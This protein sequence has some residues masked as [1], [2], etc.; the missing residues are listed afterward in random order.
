MELGQA[1]GVEQATYELIAALA[2]LDRKNT[3]RVL[4][5]RAACWEWDFPPQFS[6]ERIPFGSDEPIAG[7]FH[8][9][10]A[11][12]L[13]GGAAAPGPAHDEAAFG[14]D[15]VHST[16]SYTHPAVIEFPGI[17]T[18]QD[19]QHLH[20]PEF[21]TRADWDE[22]ERLYRESARRA[23][24]IICGS[25]FTRRDVHQRYGIPLEK[26]T[27][28]WNI[29]SSNAWRELPPH[30]CR[31]LLD[32]M[33][34]EGPFL[35][36]PAHCWPHKNHARLVQAMGLADTRLPR[37]L[38]VVLTGNPFPDD[39]PA[40]AML[41]ER[42]RESRVVHLGYRSPQEFRALLQSCRALVFPSLFEGF[43][44]PVAEAL[45]AGKA[46][47]CSNVTSLPEIAGDAAVTF[48]PADPADIAARIVEVATNEDLRRSLEHAARRRRAAFS[49]WSCAIR[50]LAVYESVF[51]E[52]AP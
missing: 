47:A 41:R 52:L 8:A 15:L 24:R 43:G 10:V 40:A 22:R 44:M 49:P 11:R 39:H 16:C 6:V 42:G 48:D 1:G 33:G 45:I 18:I 29:P 46:V 37:D 23:R 19:L 27:T 21:F 26:M 35:L 7:R 17:L 14:F 31:A 4:A 38:K 36:Y 2:R 20:Y 12:R 34:V 50:T 5:P 25:E 30:R 9:F 3:Y 32:A 51:A 13:E 28:I